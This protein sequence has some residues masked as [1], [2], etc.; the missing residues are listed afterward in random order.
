MRGDFGPSFGQP[1][2]AQTSSRKFSVRGSL[3]S[4]LAEADVSCVPRSATAA[5][6]RFP[7]TR[8]LSHQGNRK[9]CPSS[10]RGS[11]GS[12]KR[13]GHHGSS[14]LNK[15]KRQSPGNHRPQALALL[16][17]APVRTAALPLLLR[18]LTLRM[19]YHI[20]EKIQACSSVLCPHR[21]GS[22]KYIMFR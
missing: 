9:S 13:S 16:L 1:L 2:M 21:Y 8:S 18:R 11:R 17:G 3:H 7:R 14:L 12:R 19:A 15:S 10:E 22:E 6:D 4:S 5:A 20:P